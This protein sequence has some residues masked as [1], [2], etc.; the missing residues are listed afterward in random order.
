MHREHP[1]LPPVILAGPTASGKSALA[2]EMAKRLQAEIISVDSR[3]C[4]R[5]LDIGT[6]KPSPEDLAA[7]PHHNISVLDPDQPDSAMAF[8]RRAQHAAEQ[9]HTR[10]RQIL[11]VGGSTLHLQTL[12]K[13]LNDLPESSPENLALLQHQLEQ[14][15]VDALFTRL[16][17]V[18]PEYAAR[19]DPKN[20][21]RLMRALDV[22]MQ[23]G[24]PFSSFH[25][26][27]SQQGHASQQG[28]GN[29]TNLDNQQNQ[30]DQISPNGILV[31]A[32]HHPRK[33]L[34]ARIEERCEQMLDQGLIRETET[35]L[36]DGF[37]PDLQ[38]FQTVGYRQVLSYLARDL[39]REQMVKDFKTATRRYAKRQITWLRRWPFVT[40]VDADASRP[41]DLAGVVMRMLREKSVTPIVRRSHSA[42]NP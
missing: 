5:R 3:Q 4:Y 16:Q 41:E 24:K 42:P 39:T 22:W 17:T 35:L 40:W 18:D 36:A 27:G 15:G 33:T 13:P 6:A 29:Q 11:Y 25:H 34:H 10:G 14:D 30:N 12:I 7:V 19:I 8:Y 2:M 21:R 37:T 31:I 28:H 9:I 20:P 38:A 1:S 32:L 26:H 23:T